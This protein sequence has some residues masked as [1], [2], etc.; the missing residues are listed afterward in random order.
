VIRP[1]T[2]NLVFINIRSGEEFREGGHFLAP[3]TR[4]GVRGVVIIIDRVVIAFDLARRQQK[5]QAQ[6]RKKQHQSRHDETPSWQ[7]AKDSEP[8]AYRSP[9]RRV[10]IILLL[11][12]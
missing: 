6:D 9:A 12:L 5:Q 11:T 7:E 3:G 2:A 8:T 4:Y 10:V 1:N